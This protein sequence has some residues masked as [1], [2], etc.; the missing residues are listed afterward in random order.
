VVVWWCGGVVVWWCGY[1]VVKPN[2]C[3]E[4]ALAYWRRLITNI[5]HGAHIL[6]VIA[7]ITRRGLVIGVS[8]V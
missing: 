3:Y 1:V 5:Q 6:V 7:V 8:S 4:S 2:S